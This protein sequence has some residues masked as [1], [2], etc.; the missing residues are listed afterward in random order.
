MSTDWL[1]AAVCRGMDPEIFFPNQGAGYIHAQRICESCP[2][3][4]PCAEAALAA[5]EAFGV[6]GGLSE[7]ERRR[8]LKHRAGVPVRRR[9]YDELTRER[10]ITLYPEVRKTSRSD[11]SAYKAVARRL[12]VSDASSVAAWVRKASEAE[13]ANLSHDHTSGGH[14][15]ANDTREPAAAR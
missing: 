2:V 5:G 9:T 15:P 7:V 1:E 6:W 14:E 8:I 11:W 10:A 3:R 13:T 12:G 4:F